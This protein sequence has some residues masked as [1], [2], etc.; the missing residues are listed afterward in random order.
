MLDLGKHIVHPMFNRPVL[1]KQ[2]LPKF[3]EQ[4]KFDRVRSN[5][6]VE[7]GFMDAP[8]DDKDMAVVF[9]K[10]QKPKVN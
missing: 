9:I 1:L 2:V 3:F 10:P 5:Q 6:Q 7:Q 8:S 4:R